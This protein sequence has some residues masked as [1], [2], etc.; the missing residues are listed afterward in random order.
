MLKIL[1]KYH[2]L[3]ENIN[4]NSTSTTKGNSFF[5]RIKKTRGNSFVKVEIMNRSQPHSRNLKKHFESY[6][7]TCCIKFLICGA[8][9]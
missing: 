4:Q 9:T 8:I 1:W 3:S 6:A 5:P 2:L 7:L